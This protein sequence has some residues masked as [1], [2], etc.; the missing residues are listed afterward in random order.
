MKMMCCSDFTNEK[1]LKEKSSLG[2]LKR[3]ERKKE[4]GLNLQKISS[5]EY[6]TLDVKCLHMSM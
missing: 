5:R 1:W 6:Q 2:I 3:I 4:S